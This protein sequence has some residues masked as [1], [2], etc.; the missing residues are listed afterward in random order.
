[1]A[2][3]L[4]I[5]SDEEYENLP[6]EDIEYWEEENERT[7]DYYN[8]TGI[9]WWQDLYDMVTCLDED[10]YS[11]FVEKFL[12]WDSPQIPERILINIL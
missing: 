9:D 4:H 3:L 8:A 11:Q 6:Q 7:I 1:M 12:S 2:T 10:H 5:I